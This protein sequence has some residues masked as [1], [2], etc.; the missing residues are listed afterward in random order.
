MQSELAISSPNAFI[1]FSGLLFHPISFTRFLLHSRLSRPSIDIEHESNVWNAIADGKRI[2]SLDYFAIQAACRSLI[3]SRRIKKTICNHAD[4]PFERGLDY[5][6]HQL[7]AAGLKKE[8]LGLRRHAGIVWSKLQKLADAFADRR[9]ARFTGQQTRNTGPMEA[10]SES[11]GLCGFSASF[12]SL[13]RDER[14]SR[15][16]FTCAQAFL[17]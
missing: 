15:H 8:Q 2:K 11:L 6:A 4:A 5:F 12:R 14:Q 17:L 7:A 1:K 16:D 10:R 13:E 9:P 3:N